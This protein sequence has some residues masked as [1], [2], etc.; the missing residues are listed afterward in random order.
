M[1]L[2]LPETITGQDVG[3]KEVVKT[4]FLHFVNAPTAVNLI[5]LATPIKEIS[6]CVPEA[7]WLSFEELEDRLKIVPSGILG[8]EPLHYV[9]NLH[10]GAHGNSIVETCVEYIETEKVDSSQLTAPESLIKSAKFGKKEQALYFQEYMD[11]CLPS[12]YMSYEVF[13]KYMQ[14]KGL[15]VDDNMTDFFRAFDLHKRKFL[16]FKEVLLGLAALEPSTQHG[17]MPA[18][19]RCRY[20]FRFYDKNSDGHLQ[21]DEFRH[22]VKDIRSFKNLSLDDESVEEDAVKSAKLFG[23]E[24]KNKLPLGEFLQAVGQLKFRGTSVLFRLQHS[25]TTSLKL[26]EKPVE[27]SSPMKDESMEPPSS[28]RLR[29]KMLDS[30]RNSPP[31]KLNMTDTDGELFKLPDVRPL[32]AK[33]PQLPR[34]ELATHTIKV[35]RTGVLADVVK[36][37]DL[38]GKILNIE[39][40][41]S[42]YEL[43]T[44]TIKVRRTGVLADVVKLWDLQGKILNIK[45][46]LSRYELATHTIKVRRTGVLADVVKLWD[47]QGEQVYLTD[48]SEIWDLQGKILNIKD[49]LSRYELATHTIKVRR[50]G[51]LADVVKL[52][53]L[54]GKILNIKDSL[55]RYELATHTIKVRRTGVLADVV[56]LWD[57]QGKILNIKD[58]LSRY[59]LA[60]H[61]IK[62]RRTG[63][64][65][66]VVKLWDL[67]GT[68]AVSG[69]AFSHLEGDINR[70]QRMGSID[71][72]NQRSHPNEMLTGLRYF[73]RALK[74]DNGS[75]AKQA[76]DWG[77][78][79]KNALAKCLL[80]LC[81]QTKEILS[82]E[83]RLVKL[84]SPVYILG[85]IHGN[86]RDLVCFEKALWRMGPMLT[87]ASF[88]FLGD[89]VDRGEYGVEVIS[90][91][92]AEKLL[93]PE[94]FVLLRG[95]HELRSVQEM[96]SFKTECIAKFGDS[97]GL[98][99]WDA[100]N[101]CFDCMPIAATVDDRIFCV[102]GGIPGPESES[103]LIENINKVPCPL[104]D[105]EIESPLAWEIMWSDPISVEQV[106]PELKEELE[107]QKGYVYN[108]RRGTAHFFSIEALTS[109]LDINGLSHVIRAHEVQEAGFQ[110]QQQGKL[111]TVFSSSGYC[112]GSNEAACV[113][114]DN[115]KLR[116]IRLDTT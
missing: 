75:P 11:F 22:M 46:S 81:R 9:K 35:R 90:Y 101:E 54:Q 96:F 100:V 23:A 98:Q 89:Y 56:K 83:P 53:D 10:D 43:A 5:Y 94:K 65:A 50:T 88:L 70:F 93:A 107:K 12:H 84:T 28:K 25:S 4:N 64:L 55:S 2:A 17:G 110:V 79:E 115:F 106:T 31:R 109:F 24:S 33:H 29:P 99:I 42:R 16:T 1:L 51:V 8:L 18:E 69:S 113:L 97:I 108:S 87:P 66:D 30:I 26:L 105:P 49:S 80:T 62:V 13:E 78:V 45:D 91:L 112:G 44:H 48:V 14:F 47:L 20:I 95:N 71:S 63:V 85:D 59:E 114:A 19:M 104:R 57:L 92:F 52:W 61:T 27:N 36:L 67:Q 38:Q 41:L 7:V 82:D 76:F 68:T 15:K 103:C 73:E 37:W 39:D 116:M 111:L 40:S 77:Q 102:H 86:Y 6:T 34:Y 3:I 21:Y 32:S 74:G 58:S 60:T 72:F